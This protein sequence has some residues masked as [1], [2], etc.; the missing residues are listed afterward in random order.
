MRAL[1]G[2]AEN[3]RVVEQAVRAA[4]NTVS[5]GNDVNL[6][7]YF[8]SSQLRCARPGLLRTPSSNGKKSGTEVQR[9]NA[10]DKLPASASGEPKPLGVRRAKCGRLH[11]LEVSLCRVFLTTHLA[12]TTAIT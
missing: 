12:M 1:P 7:T 8:T 11:F 2:E 9:T 5:P 10:G 3:V 4:A 6:G